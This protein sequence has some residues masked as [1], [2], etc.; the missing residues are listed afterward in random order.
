MGAIV[1]VEDRLLIIALKEC[2]TPEPWM[3]HAGDVSKLWNQSTDLLLSATDCKES[4]L[5][6]MQV[7]LN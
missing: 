3:T 2:S 1:A 5:L 7:V 4:K 6:H